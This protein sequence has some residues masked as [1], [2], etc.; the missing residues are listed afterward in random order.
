[1][2]PSQKFIIDSKGSPPSDAPRASDCALPIPEFGEDFQLDQTG[3][4]PCRAKLTY[5]GEKSIFLTIN[6]SCE[7]NPNRGLRLI[8]SLT[9]LLPRP[10]LTSLTS[11]CASR[12]GLHTWI[13]PGAL[14]TRCRGRTCG[15][16]RVRLH[17]QVPHPQTPKRWDRD[18][19]SLIPGPSTR[20]LASVTRS[21]LCLWSGFAPQPPE[22]SHLSRTTCF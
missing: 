13:P 18:P 17:A 20:Y 14:V 15:A 21:S 11:R 16:P 7:A 1:M 5:P 22:Y 19:L 9:A 12:D 4:T 6:G 8:A 10:G 3:Q 2:R